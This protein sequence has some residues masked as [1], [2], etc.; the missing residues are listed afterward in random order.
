MQRQTLLRNLR[1]RGAYKSTNEW[2]EASTRQAHKDLFKIGKRI[3]ASQRLT[4]LYPRRTSCQL[5]QWGSSVAIC[6]ATFLGKVLKELRISMHNQITSRSRNPSQG[7]RNIGRQ[8][9]QT[10]W[11]ASAKK[12]PTE[13]LSQKPLAQ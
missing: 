10:S 5:K 6:S 8:T 11:N 3:W 2:K 1:V 4:D 13:P 7:Y 9:C 12:S